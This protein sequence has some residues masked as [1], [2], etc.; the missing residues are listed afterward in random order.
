MTPAP[1][2][3]PPHPDTV[4]AEIERPFTLFQPPLQIVPVVVD[5]PHAGRRYP[6]AFVDGARLPLRLLR[7][8]EDAYVDLLFSGTVA[9]G[10]PLLVAEFPRAYLDLNREPYELD[11]RM[12]EGRLPGHA[13]T[14]S[15]RVAGGLGTIPRIVGDA[16]EIYPGRIPVEVA[17]ARIEE[18]YRPYHA[19]LRHL[20]SR[21]QG[22]FGTCVL[23]DA[24]SMP[25]TGL[26]RDGLAKP[27]IILGD[28]FGS[29]AAG[30]VVD[31]AE[32]AF[33]RAGLSV[34][35]NRP[36][37]GG[38]ITEHYGVP[39]AG[40]HALQIEINRGLYMNE[41]TLEPNGGFAP[42]RA[43]ITAAMAEC[44][45]RWSGWIDEWRQA[46]E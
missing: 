45:A 29:S 27:D 16:C 6:A 17:L 33:R 12:F 23:V 3:A 4:V 43:V 11:P 13:N 46:A 40:V 15:L 41:Q 37:A 34:T 19:G 8:S 5:V 38:F 44:F 20:V 18:L 36:Y 7:R 21:T 14:R 2:D 35:R 30:F 26:D 32:A 22:C 39:A 10:A 24:H 42:L 25:S 31:A 9:L 1:A 28:R